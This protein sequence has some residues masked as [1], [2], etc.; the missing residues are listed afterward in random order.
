MNTISEFPYRIEM[1]EHVEIPMPDGCRLAA[2]I[3]LPENAERQPVPAILEYIPYRKRDMT[4]LRDSIMHPYLAGHGYA[5][6]RVDL[7]GSGESGGVLRDQ[8]RQRE[9]DDGAAVIAWLAE[10]SW[11]DGNVGM[12]GI[13]WGGFNAL[14]VASQAPPAL[15]AVVSVCST[16]D[17]YFDNMHYMG[18]C[19]L[20]DNLSEATTM[21]SANT[22]PPDPALVGDRWREM[23]LQRLHG[24]GL[25]LD[26]WLRHQYRDEYWQH[27]SVSEHYDAIRCP[28]MLVG[29]WADGYT[30]AIFRLLE[31]LQVP[32]QGLIGPWGHKY[33]HQGVPGPAIGF[34]Q[35]ALRWWDRWLKGHDTGITREPMLRAWMQ[36]SVPPTTYYQERPGRWV[37]EEVWPAPQI[38]NVAYGL[39]AHRI[40]MPGEPPCPGDERVDVQSPLSVGLLAGKWCSYTAAPDLPHDQRLEDGGSLVFESAPL[41]RELEILGAPSAE[42]ELAC[43]Q[44]VAMVAAR[45]SDVA[46]DGKATRVTYGLYNLTH[47]KS[48][49]EPEQLVPGKVYR[50]SVAMNAIGQNFPA[51]HRL[52]LSLSTSY[53]A[54]AWPSP[55]PV[56]MTV[57]PAASRL[58]L[59]EREPRPEDADIRFQKPEGAPRAPVEIIEPPE[60]NWLVHRNLA[61]DQS[62]LEVIKNEG[63][64]RIQEIDMEVANR[65]WNWYSFCDDD[66][67]S[68]RGETRTERLFRRGNWS[69]RT[70]TRTVLTADTEYFYIHAELDAWEGDSRVFTENWQRKIPRD[71]L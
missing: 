6:V 58:V 51:G 24:S 19:L 44:P 54:L 59:P 64:K 40:L 4:R 48:H 36:E 46:P 9:L 61:L 67:E 18:G 13:S 32:R 50:V 69:V 56:R 63:L 35:E 23:W 3:W 16:D 71:H 21:F 1:R 5:C 41:E 53:W 27:G 33:P 20:T 45:L 55:R 38:H 15:K 28:V 66:F 70:T 68:L 31:H 22:C 47:R 65:T 30:N 17:L 37:G 26:T 39:D 2:R 12:M 52:R 14:Q 7:R 8:Y 57:Y 34:L 29:G 62:V 42:L 60:H 49:A 25:W 10:Q 11:C 43:N